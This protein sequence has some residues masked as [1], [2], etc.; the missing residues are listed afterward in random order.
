MPKD[1]ETTVINAIQASNP[2][3]A[4]IDV[5]ARS[6]DALAKYP[7]FFNNPQHRAKV[8]AVTEL[9]E[10]FFVVRKNIYVNQR[11]GRGR[12][13]TVIKVDHPQWPRMKAADVTRVY[14]EPLA[15]LGVEIVFSARTNSYL[16]R[17]F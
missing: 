9:L 3:A 2:V 16:Y 8:A 12:P 6:A 10:D 15:K 1:T 7:K 13:F 11:E 5:Q 17:I 14:R 4:V